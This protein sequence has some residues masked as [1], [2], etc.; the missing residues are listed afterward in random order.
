MISSASPLV[1]DTNVAAKWFFDE[2]YSQQ[3]LG[4]LDMFGKGTFRPLAP[5]LIYAEFANVVWKRVTQN[6]LKVE[7]GAAII[8][9]FLSLPIEITPSPLILLSAYHLSHEHGRSVYDALFLALCL[10]ANAEFVTA[11]ES[12][13]H[14][15]R[16]RISQVRW[17]GNWPR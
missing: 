15:V 13:Y 1:I 6:G 8:S 12:L 14:A 4:L 2:P 10:H 11:D 17:I 5:D 3:A 9:A 7:D 16:A